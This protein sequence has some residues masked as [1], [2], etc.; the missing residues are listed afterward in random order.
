VGA[1]PIVCWTLRV[2]GVRSVMCCLALAGKEQRNRSESVSLI[3]TFPGNLGFQEHDVPGEGVSMVVYQ[4]A[5]SH[6][7][8]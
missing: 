4:W 3:G 8:G 5:H 1:Q 7:S 6:F 2:I